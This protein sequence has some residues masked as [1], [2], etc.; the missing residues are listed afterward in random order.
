MAVDG[1]Q[2]RP[3]AVKDRHEGGG[4]RGQELLNVGWPARHDPLQVDTSGEGG[5]GPSDHHRR[6]L[7]HIAH[8]GRERLQ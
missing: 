4:E 2:H 3:G 7:V 8:R 5:S 1:G 6:A